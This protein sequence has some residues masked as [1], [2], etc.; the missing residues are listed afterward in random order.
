VCEGDAI[1]VVGGVES[2][3][4]ELPADGPGEPEGVELG[5]RRGRN[6]RGDGSWNRRNRWDGDYTD[7]GD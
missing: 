5:D 4:C 7:V 6:L 2:T 3:V 1:G